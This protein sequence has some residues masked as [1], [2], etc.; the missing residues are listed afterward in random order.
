MAHRSATEKH[1]QT[2]PQSTERAF[3]CKVFVKS[4]KFNHHLG[5]M[6][7]ADLC[8]A[9]VRQ[10]GNPIVIESGGLIMPSYSPELIQIMRAALEDVMTKIPADQATPGVKA[11]VAEVILKAA[12]EGQTSFEGLLASASAQIQIILSLLT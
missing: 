1:D 10:C 8:L 11:H 3:G 6:P 9:H 12:A 7:L 4:K 2:Q 5:V